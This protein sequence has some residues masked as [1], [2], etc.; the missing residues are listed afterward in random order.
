MSIGIGQ[1]L[2][3]HEITALLGKGGMGEVYRARDL[4]LKRDVAI[5]ILPEEFSRDADRVSRFLREAEVLASLN[6]PNIGAIYDLEEAN[7]A[8]FLVLELVEGETLAERIARGPIPI[9]EALTIAKQIVEALEAAH[10][11]GIVHRD[12]KPANVKITPDGKVKVLDFGL[13]KALETQSPNATLSS[14]PTMVSGTMGGMIIGTAAYMSPEQARGRAADQRSDVF[15][16]GCALFEM[17]AGRQAFQGEDVSDVIAS[18]IKGDVDFDSLPS[19]L[20]PRLLELLR[21]S[22]AKNRSDRWHAMG[23]IRLEIET[24]MADPHGLR[25]RTMHAVARPWWKPVITVVV[26]AVLVAGLTVVTVRTL[27]PVQP[28]DVMRLSFALPQDQSLTNAGRHLVTISPDGANIVYVA[29]QRLYL[30]RIADM[31]ARPIPGTAMQK[32]AVT[33]PFFS[34]DGGWVGFWASDQKLKKIAITGGVPVTL[35]DAQNPY[36][37]TWVYDDQIYFGEA[38]KGIM[39]V[40]AKGGKPETAVTVNPG[41]AAHG[42]Q[43]LPGGDV[44]LFTVIGSAKLVGME[45]P[46]WDNAQIVAQSLKTGE[47]HLVLQGGSDARYVPTGHLVYALGSTL[48]AAPFDVRKLQLTAAAVPVVDNVA[49][50]Q[51]GNTGAAQFAFSSKGSMVYIPEAAGARSRTVAL[52]D[53]AGIR[54][55]LDIPPAP[56]NHPRISP[57]GKQLALQTNDGSNAHIWIYDMTGAASLRQLTFTGRD[58]WPIWTRDGQ[59]VVFMSERDTDGG[60][61]WQRADGVSTAEQLL[62]AE[63]GTLLKPET[64]SADEKL[65]FSVNPNREGFIRTLSPGAAPQTLIEAP[66]ISSTLSRDG[67]WLAYTSHG[68]L[69]VQPFPLT[70]AKYRIPTTGAHFP[71]WSPDGRKLFYATD[72]IAGTSKIVSL[73]I[74]KQPAF[75]FG[76]PTPLPVEGIVSNQERGGF[77]VM[78]DGKHFVVLLP[79]SQEPG[80]AS[81]EQ[82]NITIN[83]FEDLKHRVPVR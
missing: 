36:G 6:H 22:L 16:F 13:A 45:I 19:N 2:G 46:Q 56:Y 72:E 42:P 50:P 29:N 77:A 73:D 67:R 24:I 47:R 4:K 25:L 71:Q 5:K 55:P 62:K 80:K 70:G 75:S 3:S 18:V 81:F 31:E 10:E 58:L 82:F 51:G 48:L 65:L 33:S 76:K 14:S 44:L 23:D 21:R 53:E 32:G 61:F 60:L 17:L 64:W 11:R 63:S 27:Q 68:E 37:A 9:E 28:A 49:R 74:Q 15:A 59:R 43:V 69:Y 30:R 34:P 54:K 52:V 7:G 39:R 78:P 26:T 1:Q 79:A 35:C 66:A 8:R 20:N 83:W 41:E 38:D 40:S 12:L 57:N